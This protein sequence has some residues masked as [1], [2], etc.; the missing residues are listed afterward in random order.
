[1]TAPVVVRLP[2]HPFP[3]TWATATKVALCMHSW[4]SIYVEVLPGKFEEMDRC[5]KCHAPRCIRRPDHREC[6]LIRNHKTVHMFA[7]GTYE[8]LG[9]PA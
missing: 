3:T 1:M 9:A 7:D 5:E 2:D 4:I 8:P 6:T